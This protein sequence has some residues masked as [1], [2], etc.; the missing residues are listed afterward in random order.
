L[1]LE[2]FDFEIKDKKGSENQVSDH[3]SRPAN[4]ELT[5]LEKEVLE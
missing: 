5:T 4:K 3:L 2:E 1:L